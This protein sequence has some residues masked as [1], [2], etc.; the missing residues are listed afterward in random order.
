LSLDKDLLIS[1][2]RQDII[3]KQQELNKAYETIERVNLFI[4]NLIEDTELGIKAT[5][6]LHRRLF[7]K[8]LPNFTDITFSSKYIVSSSESSSYYDFINIKEGESFG[9]IVSDTY[10]YGLSAL[11]M[12]AITSLI[13][14]IFNVDSKGILNTLIGEIDEL[15]L[16]K[17][18]EKDLKDDIA[19]FMLNFSR[20]DLSIEFS[21]KDMPGLFVLRNNLITYLKPEYD[22]EFLSTKF[23]LYPADKLIVFNNGLINSINN[24]GKKF[25]IEVL[26]SLLNDLKTLPIGDIVHNIGYEVNKHSSNKRSL[27]GGDIVILGIELEKRILYVV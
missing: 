15:I 27:L 25:N 16:S 2:L 4:E 24:D 11:I 1:K 3:D 20:S 19:L 6:N 7:S 9:I 21:G 10:G 13:D 23:K 8:K 17:Q 18:K 26:E 14:R 22:N 5:M 12:G